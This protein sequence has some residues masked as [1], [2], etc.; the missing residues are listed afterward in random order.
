MDPQQY[1][2]HAMAKPLKT[3]KNPV[4][5]GPITDSELKKSKS[6]PICD[7]VKTRSLEAGCHTELIHRVR[8]EKKEGI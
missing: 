8:E 2:G 4:T 6:P 5:L 7:D 3:P 1:H